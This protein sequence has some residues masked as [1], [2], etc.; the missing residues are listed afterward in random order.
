MWLTTESVTYAIITNVGG[1][2]YGNVF[3]L[4][5]QKLF[6]ATDNLAVFQES[7]ANQFPQAGT[8]TSGD[9][10]Y[11]IIIQGAPQTEAFAIF[12]QTVKT[13][14]T[15]VFGMNQAGTSSPGLYTVGS[16]SYVAIGTKST[17]SGFTTQGT[18][19]IEYG[20]GALYQSGVLIK[21]SF[22][23]GRTPTKL[24]FEWLSVTLDGSY[25]PVY[26]TV[27]CFMQVAGT[28][29]ELTFTNSR[30]D[31]YVNEYP[32]FLLTLLGNR[33]YVF[34]SPVWYTWY[35]RKA[36]VDTTTDQITA[37]SAHV[38]ISPGQDTPLISPIQSYAL[39]S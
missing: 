39:K 34:V 9:V 36:S 5:C 4:V 10:S 35:L 32:S 37:Q 24:S 31:L 14:S 19:S 13:L 38:T 20:Y 11:P 15:L 30:S 28:I 23:V 12:S 8:G 27:K 29:T 7:L 26:G 18:L 17:E 6:T 21:P 1:G 16:L 3:G 25:N 2:H 33:S 22:V